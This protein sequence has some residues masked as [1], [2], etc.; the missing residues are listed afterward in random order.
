MKLGNYF[1]AGDWLLLAAS[2]TEALAHGRV[3]WGW[4]HPGFS[5]Y[6]GVPFLY[7]PHKKTDSGF[8][9]CMSVPSVFCNMITTL[10]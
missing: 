1:T 10:R 3:Y 9:L 8:F 7:P 6:F 2:S 5:F 4:G